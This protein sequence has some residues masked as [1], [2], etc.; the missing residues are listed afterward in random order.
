MNEEVTWMNLFFSSNPPEFFKRE[1]TGEPKFLH[2]CPEDEN[3]K[4]GGLVDRSRIAKENNIQVFFREARVYHHIDRFCPTQERIYFPRFY[5]V[6]TNMGRSRFLSGYAN[7]RA[8]VLE[9]IK[10]HFPFEYKWYCSLLKDRLRCLNALHQIG[11][12]HG[13]VKDHHFRLP[14]DI[15]D[16]VLYNFSELYTFSNK[17]PFRINSNRPQPLKGLQNKLRQACL[18]LG[19]S[20]SCKSVLRRDDFL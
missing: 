10:P 11:V 16:T 4:L 19:L 15:Y 20:E 9:A 7:R 1:I 12:T 17:W 6:V 13:D 8:A 3:W 18:H 2:F 14:D 5:G